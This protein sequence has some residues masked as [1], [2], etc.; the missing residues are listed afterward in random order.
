MSSGKITNMR[1]KEASV[2]S[3]PIDYKELYE[4][5]LFIVLD[6]CQTQYLFLTQTDTF[7]G[8]N[9][10]NYIVIKDQKL[11]KRHAKIKTSCTLEKDDRITLKKTIL[12]YLTAGE[13]ENCTDK[14]LPIYNKAYLLT[15]LEEAF[16]SARDKQEDL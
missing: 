5:C 11:G 7:V 13:Y 6:T 9:E 14:L 2:S 12:K 16:T 10:S 15:T 8:R 3:T 1:N 4:T